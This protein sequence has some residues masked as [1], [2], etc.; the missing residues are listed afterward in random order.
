VGVA[1]QF[2]ATH[3]QLAE[4]PDNLQ[5]KL[6]HDHPDKGPFQTVGRGDFLSF[7]PNHEA[8][9]WRYRRFR[10]D[11]SDVLTGSTPV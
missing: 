5:M 10:A 11:S 8:L 1:G 4:Y 7:V 2:P 9:D 6:L 3:I